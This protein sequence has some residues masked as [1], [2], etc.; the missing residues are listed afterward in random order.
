MKIRLAI[1]ALALAVAPSFAAAMGGCSW[2]RTT[3]SASACG[4]GQVWD[5]GSETCITPVTG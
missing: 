3:T 2:E 4:E 1:A 5:A